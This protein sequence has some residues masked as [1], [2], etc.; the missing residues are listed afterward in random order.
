M[1]DARRMIFL[2]VIRNARPV[3]LRRLG[4]GSGAGAGGGKVAL[5][6][7]NSCLIAPGWKRRGLALATAAGWSRIAA[8]TGWLPVPWFSLSLLPLVFSALGNNF[9]SPKAVIVGGRL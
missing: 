9:A 3:S 2:T 5:T 1:R 4:F 7:R 6:S 8:L